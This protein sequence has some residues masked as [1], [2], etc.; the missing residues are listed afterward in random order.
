MNTRT[1]VLALA[2][3]AVMTACQSNKSAGPAPTNP[4]LREELLDILQDDQMIRAEIPL[5]IDADGDLDPKFIEKMD[6][7]DAHNRERLN[8][9]ID[10]HGWP[11]ISKTGEQGATS[12]FIIALH[13]PKTEMPFIESCLAYMQDAAEYGQANPANLA[14]L[15][16]RVRMYNQQPQVYGT[17][18]IDDENGELMV[19]PIAD[20]DRLDQRRASVGLPPFAEYEAMVRETDFYL[21]RP[22]N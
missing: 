13:T 21:A 22:D 17:Q 11:T 8:L 12:A 1:F 4:Y 6:R 9:I 3:A 18:F 14:Y 5:N 19:Y 7:V 20:V 15:E 2:A 10:D 16:D